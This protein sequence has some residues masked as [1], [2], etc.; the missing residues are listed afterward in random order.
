MHP[1]VSWNRT[2]SVRRVLLLSLAA[3]CVSGCASSRI[4]GGGAAS[5]APQLSVERFLQA[6]NT[7]DLVSMSRLFGTSSG[8]MGDTGSSFGCFWKRI[9]T[10]FGGDSCRKWRE[11]ELQ[12]DVLAEIL[13]HE[14]YRIMSERR[15][16]GREVET[17]R[18][19]V[20]LVINSRRTVQDVGFMLVPAGDSRWLVQEIEVLK[21][22]NRR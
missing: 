12:M 18:L 16:A 21:I 1:T 8:P 6:V 20:N 15:V 9:G 4:G 5:I 22:T 2:N 10:L 11:V 14:D 13:R 19:G 17:I 3:L 7:R